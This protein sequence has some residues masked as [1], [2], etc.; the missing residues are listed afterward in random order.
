MD[1]ATKNRL[2]RTLPSVE[3]ILS[4]PSLAALLDPCPR[5]R[6]VAAARRAVDAARARL[7]DGEKQPFEDADVERALADLGRPNLVRVL[8]ATGVV[9]HTN[10]GRAPL[11]TVAADRV[12]EIASGYSNL[13]YDLTE[14]ERGSRYAPLQGLLRELTGA[15]DAV[16]VNNNAAAVLLALAAL[17]P[18]R[19]AVVSRGELVEI[20]GG[21]RIPD[22]MRQSGARLREVG[23]TNRTRVED[24]AEAIGPETALLMKVH[25]SNFEVVGFTEEVPVKA[26]AELARSRGLP[27]FEDLGS[28]CIVPLQG[29]GL[30]AEPTVRGSVSA[31]VD[32]CAFSGDKLLGGPQAGILVGQPELIAKV[33]RHPLNRALRVDKMTVAAL[34]ATLE[35]YRDGRVEEL[36][37][38]RLLSQ[39]AAEIQARAGRLQDRLA[40]VG[41]SCR[42]I[43]TVSQVGGGAMPLASPVSYAC[44]VDA[45]SATELQERLRRGSP[46]VIAR[47]S[48][49]Q[50]LLDARCLAEAEL[51]TVAEVVRAAVV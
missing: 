37:A 11:A 33:R 34:E 50:L 10:L 38:Y 17:A 12:R 20:G 41:V 48:D 18:G 3:E 42:V 29:E 21:F 6:A 22:V 35:L 26:L 19:E 13:E 31:G 2:L 7:L 8:N 46:P 9:L 32:L 40:A 23:T 36:P 47:V 15:P 45:R 24:Y 1:E 16:V 25:R 39:R 49:E 51:E 14:G 30:T 28:G 44:A 27:L 5:P 43:E 4:R